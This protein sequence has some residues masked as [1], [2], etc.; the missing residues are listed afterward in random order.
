MTKRVTAFG[1]H[2]GDQ[3]QKLS[4]LAAKYAK[5]SENLLLFQALHLRKA[6]PGSTISNTAQF[7]HF[8]LFLSFSYFR[9]HAAKV[10]NYAVLEKTRRMKQNEMRTSRNEL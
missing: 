4:Y 6:I 10:V 2:S 8:T 1:C 5:K 9:L 7:P 3:P